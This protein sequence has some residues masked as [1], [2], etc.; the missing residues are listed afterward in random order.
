VASAQQDYDWASQV[1]VQRLGAEAWVLQA[2]GRRHAALDMMRSAAALEEKIEKHPVTPGPVLPARE[3]TGE[4]LM[5]LD[6]PDLAVREFEAALLAAPK[7]F[8]ALYGSARASELAGQHGRAR[9]RY[10]QLLAIADHA[11]GRTLELSN[12]RAYLAATHR[13]S[14]RK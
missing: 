13:N 10:Q 7:R 9:E 4:M 6:R 2:E 1:E 3:L 8:N 5:E 11:D 14:G 12:A